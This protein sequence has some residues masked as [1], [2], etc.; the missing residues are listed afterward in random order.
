MSPPAGPSSTP[1]P[2]HSPPD[3]ARIVHAETIARLEISTW[4]TDA[5]S[6]HV[7]ID[8]ANRQGHHMLYEDLAGA[9]RRLDHDG[10]VA[11]VANLSDIIA[12]KEWADRPRTETPFPSS[13]TC[14]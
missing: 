5:G 7:L 14:G 2:E 10:L 9:A 1:S 11:R 3:V 8:I 4:Q 13:T 6:L 12:S